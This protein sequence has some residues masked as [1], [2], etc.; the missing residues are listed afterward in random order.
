MIF[1][2]KGAMKDE[3]MPSR[4]WINHLAVAPARM[5]P[6]MGAALTAR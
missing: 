3:G 4:D 2:K 1:T 5:A 6:R